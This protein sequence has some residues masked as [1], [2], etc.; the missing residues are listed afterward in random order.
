MSRF[1]VASTPS[2]KRALVVTPALNG[3]G[4]LLA[5]VDGL[6]DNGDIYAQSVGFDGLLGSTNG[7]GTRYC[8]PA[9]PNASG[10]PARLR[11]TG[12]AFVSQNDLWLRADSLTPNAFA[13]FLTSRTQGFTAGPGGSRG[14]LC[15]AGSIGR[16][17]GGAIVN[18]GAAGAID[19]RTNLTAMPQ[20][21]GAVAVLVGD[22][23]NFQT[24]YRDTFAGAPTSNFSDAVSVTFQ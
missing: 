12:S 16:R 23:W 22:T 1:E 8:S 21:A 15:L 9:V 14:N 19:L 17:V 7:F 6:V 20:P 18:S 24:W 11:V 10:A 5:W 2:I 3:A 4:A 13:Y